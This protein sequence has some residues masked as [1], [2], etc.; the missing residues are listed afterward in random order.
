MAVAGNQLN[1]HHGNNFEN[2]INESL[3]E[4]RN[5][6]IMNKTPHV[7]SE[8]HPHQYQ[9]KYLMVEYLTSTS[10]LSSLMILSKLGLLAHDIAKLILWSRSQTL[11]L[12]FQ[13]E[14][15]SVLP[16]HVTSPLIE[17]RL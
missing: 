1:R 17:S 14:E 11:T 10:I 13:A 4:I 3:N 12:R 16:L 5:I 9:D 8:G 15:R 7:L 2:Q 6:L